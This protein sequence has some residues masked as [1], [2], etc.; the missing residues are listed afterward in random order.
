MAGGFN[1][2][3]QLG[4]ASGSIVINTDDL[5]KAE[6]TARRVGS[7]VSR[8]LGGIRGGAQQAQQ[9]M[10]GL[11]KQFN[12][13]AGAG[14]LLAGALAGLGLREIVRRF[15][16]A[17]TAAS[18]LQ[19]T[20]SKTNAVFRDNADEMLEWSQ[21]SA[22]A[23]GLSQ[24]AALE[25]AGTVGNMFDQLGAGTAEAARLSKG[26]V[27]LSADIASFHNVSGGATEVLVAMQSAF[28]GEYDALQ[29]YIP[30]IT[31]AAVEQ[32][33]L[34]DTGKNNAKQLSML[35]KA[36]AA[37]AIIVRDAGAAVGDF[38][39]TSF[40]AANQQRILAAQLENAGGTIGRALLPAYR[41]VL[42]ILNQIVSDV[43]PYAEN[44]MASFAGGLARAINRWVVPALSLMRQ[45]FAFWLRPGSP[46]RLLPD[47]TKWG[48]G[49]AQAYLEGWTHAD[50]GV[51]DELAGQIESVVRSFAGA[52]RIG[53]TDLVS[54]VFG[55]RDA[56][57]RAADEFRQTGT[58]SARALDDIA[59]AAGPAGDSIRGLVATYFQLQTASRA[60]AEAQADLLEVTR[61]YDTALAPL[62]DKLRAVQNQQADIR[63]QQRAA[64]LNREIAD[65][66]T[67]ES[68]RRLAQL[69]LEEI[70]LRRQQR[71]LET[72]RDTAVDA[73]QAKADAAEAEEAARRDAY[74]AQ[75]ELVDQQVE[76]NRLVEEEINLRERLAREA[77]AEQEKAQRELEQAQKRAAD[78]AERIYDAELRYRLASTDTA[79]Q[80]A[81]M[82]DELAK[83]TVGSAE[84]YDI[85]TQIIG[86]EEQLRK[87]RERAGN[88]LGGGDD[89]EKPPALDTEVL[90]EARREWEALAESIRNAWNAVSGQEQEQW[91]PPAWDDPLRRNDP[92][93][94]QERPESPLPEWMETA[95]QTIQDIVDAFRIFRAEV[96]EW[97]PNLSGLNELSKEFTDILKV[98]RGEWTATHQGIETETEGTYNVVKAIVLNSLRSLWAIFQSEFVAIN[99]VLS[100][101]LHLLRMVWAF[102]LLAIQG[103]WTGAWAEIK[104]NFGAAMEE[105]GSVL[106]GQLQ[107]FASLIDIWF[108]LAPGTIEGHLQDAWQAVVDWGASLWDAG[109]NA[110]KNLFGGIK[111]YWET[112]VAPWWQNNALGRFA[113]LLPGSE[114]KDPQ[115]PLRNLGDRGAAII[116]NI[117]A[118][119]DRRVLD[120]APPTAQALTAQAAAAVTNNYFMFDQQFSTQPD[121]GLA[122]AAS[123]DG[124]LAA[125]RA[126]GR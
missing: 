71:L 87:E 74:A 113:D 79:G 114:P 48:E 68:D 40:E 10:A 83:T 85:L 70:E 100:A 14:K 97:Q 36:Y 17:V 91:T 31:A 99:S 52:G 73:A 38:E 75:R 72:E 61:R 125:Q 8:S 29:R 77:L 119:M 11:G 90:G 67:R 51:F 3:R 92:M 88:L 96:D 108:G 107:L 28:R 15:A 66:N 19:E 34:A 22:T 80:I 54:R 123:R 59:R 1:G 121:W 49:A 32:Q 81:I 112:T 124:V 64:E 115:S 116:D 62:N 27:E 18:D 109:Y 105:I 110:I 111:Y 117:M 33:A 120:I 47:L 26:L 53:E 6:V 45:I 23:F 21:G 37:Q 84:Y 7:N 55:S 95:L 102:T 103:E 43:A 106:L 50:L 2:G 93:G 4:R 101:G 118:G 20:I 56:I 126:R 25:A 98:L 35:E 82:R 76:A 122:R 30:T 58:V 46:P 41:E 44:I 86:L 5:G 42:R 94:P 9:G 78:E 13:T 104:R 65:V 39:R 63:D 12:V 60:V 69:E 24:Q 89:I 16:G 57:R